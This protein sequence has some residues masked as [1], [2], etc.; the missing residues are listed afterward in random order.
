MKRKEETLRI[1][2]YLAE[3]GLC[4][5]R[6]ADHL[7][8]MGWVRCNGKI[9]DS[10]GLQVSPSDEIEL[11][12]EAKQWL[13]SKFTVVLNKPPGF[14]SSQPE[15]G[16]KAAASLVTSDNYAGPA[17]APK[18]NIRN[19]APA[20]RLDIDSTGLL[21][22]TQDGSLAKKIIGETSSV[23]KEYE[24]RVEGH[25]T[26]EKIKKLKHGLSLDGK[27]LKMAKV[28][29]LGPQKLNM[30]LTEGKKR[31]IRRMCQL[32]DLEVV[33][34]KRIRVGKIELGRLPRGQWRLL[35]E[36]EK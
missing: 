16:Y 11:L 2:K 27:K 29:R 25:L 22:L 9:I 35:K 15:K 6:E 20:G 32:L 10:A 7:V 14:V 24:I 31:Q 33:R 19:L 36:N 30:I 21:I 12:P 26:D 17:P 3:Q 34:L 28:R 5:R 18:I 23:E 4:S 8:K 13:G 1:N